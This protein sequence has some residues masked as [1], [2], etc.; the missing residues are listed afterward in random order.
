MMMSASVEIIIY[1][2]RLVISKIERNDG[3]QLATLSSE[4]R[5]LSNMFLALRKFGLKEDKLEYCN[6]T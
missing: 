1:R 5:N 3:K 4:I 6:S 2:A